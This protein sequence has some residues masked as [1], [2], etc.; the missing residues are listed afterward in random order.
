MTRLHPLLLLAA[1]AL[2]PWTGE[3]AALDLPVRNLVLKEELDLSPAK[4]AKVYLLFDLEA[5]KVEVKA[6]GI[7]LREI[8][9]RGHRRWS[10]P[11]GIY[12][13]SLTA[14]D[15]YPR[16]PELVPPG[17]SAAP[18]PAPTAAPAAGG[19]TGGATG[20]TAPPADDALE[21]KD[22]PQEYRLEL[23]CGITLAVVGRGE[24]DR[25]GLG[26][27]K[28]FGWYLR[29]PL[30]T[31]SERMSNRIYRVVRLD[32]EDDDAR[33]LFWSFAEGAAAILVLP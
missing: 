2:F 11:P 9:L 25:G 28:E 24:K 8:P 12:R 19:G 5:G 10:V 23:D 20:A 27:L 18:T 30:T 32:M 13:C 7:A 3:T 16:R 14:K 33:A 22:M 4:D 21:L 29:A 15:P 6:K 17:T 31:L 26:R 1:L